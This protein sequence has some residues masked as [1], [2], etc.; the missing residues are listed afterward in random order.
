M[1]SAAG[2]RMPILGRLAGK[3]PERLLL[4]CY[5]D[6]RG[7]TTVCENIFYLQHLS[8]FAL[9]VVNF[10]G[11]DWPFRLSEAMQ[12][13]DVDGLI[14][15]NTLGYNAEV[16]E[17][18]DA[19]LPVGLDR[20]D[21]VK[22]LMKQDENFRA[23]R[24]AKWVG[25]RRIDLI[26]TCLDAP[27]REKVYPESVTGPVEFLQMLTGYIMP[28]MRAM[29]PH[30][31]EDRP[32]DIGY[33]G[34]IQPLTFGRLAYEKR[35]I[36]DVVAAAAARR[37]LRVD[38]SSRWEDRFSGHAWLDFLRRCKS[39]LGT[40]SGASIFD[41]DGSVER[42]YAQ[43]LQKEGEHLDDVQWCES[44]LQRFAHLEGNVRYA[45]LSPRHFEAAA[46][47]T[48]QILYE[49]RY[50]DILKP[51]RHFW[52][53]RRDLTNFDE[54]ADRLDDRAVVTATAQAAYEE[55]VCDRQWWVESFVDRVDERLE[56]LLAR[57]GRLRA[58]RRSP[59]TAKRHVVLL[60]P[61]RFRL[62][63]RLTWIVDHPPDDMLIHAVASHGDQT[64]D[65]FSIASTGA[66][67]W[68]L[69]VER[70]ERDGAWLTGA[71]AA[72][73]NLDAG[74]SSLALLD[75]LRRMDRTELAAWL[76]LTPDSQREDD[77]RWFL[78]YF[79]RTA[80][81]LVH[82]TLAMR[83]IHAIVAADLDTL[84]A[85]VILKDILKVPL[86]YD[87]HEYWPDS[88]S[89]FSEWEIAFWRKWE[90]TLTLHVDAAFTV[91][92]P[93]AEYMSRIYGIAFQTVP[94]CVPR[95]SVGNAAKRQSHSP[96][97][98]VRFL[99]QGIFAP[100]RG[101]EALIRLWPRT[102]SRAILMLR[103]PRHAYSRALEDLA[104]EA[105][106]LNTRVL[107]LD[108]VPET[109]LIAAASEADVG[110][111]P[112]EPIN[113]NN[114]YCC[115]NKLSQYCAA[116]LALLSNRLDYVASIVQAGDFGLIEDLKRP[117]DFVAA[118]DR[119]T[120][121]STLRARLQA[122]ALA[123]FQRK[124]NW[125]EAAVPLY[126][127]LDRLTKPAGVAVGSTLSLQ[128]VVSSTATPT[129][130]GAGEFAASQPTASPVSDAR[131]RPI[132]VQP[133]AAGRMGRLRSLASQPGVS[134][135]LMRRALR[136]WRRLPPSFRQRVL[137]RLR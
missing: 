66:G 67:G 43:L 127:A 11:R 3:R 7:I 42:Q 41:L 90:Q 39:V 59:R 105:G 125:D 84:A 81:A 63:P 10:F 126:D 94:N 64:G 136:T 27:E 134:G 110:V 56:T 120:G 123:F 82:A 22:V 75:A 113:I 85:G 96:S 72:D 15:H 2:P 117:D 130:P 116:G 122:N 57:K 118:V 80:A 132:L 102:D 12:W 100:G 36:G 114:Q 31:A 44:V 87:A 107:F 106:V 50:S 77:F 137:Q 83:P 55:V 71:N 73:A 20:F 14:I 21:G 88:Y 16:L 128:P 95:G 98:P 58:S 17:S 76:G 86:I 119:L 32:I 1:G 89:T 69:E 37:S 28:E 99:Y 40:E 9:E 52:P 47:G 54:I 103:G 68:L 18:L 133:T 23:P 131:E 135:G 111:L 51:W 34:S 38:I 109:Q 91:S 78:D 129:Q 93:L 60:A 70:G 25:E 35:Q 33:R 4:L 92:S 104:A 26:L 124:F 61:H 62:D 30:P 53:L 79:L 49:G 115:P 6:P 19:S 74:R 108:P 121:D 48:V 112:Y 65:D 24:I 13:R 46:S 97:G 5:Y 8:S 29:R 101:L 45:Q